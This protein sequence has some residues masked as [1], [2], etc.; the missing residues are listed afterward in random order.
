M[1]AKTFKRAVTG[2]VLGMAVG[3]LIAAL[4]GHPNIV[5]P[6]LL[7]KAGGLSEALLWQTLL[8]GVIGGVAWAGMS[9][10]ELERWPLL[11][12]CAAH[13]TLILAAFLPI[14]SFLG[15]LETP[16]EMLLMAAIM[17]VAHFIVFLIMCAVYRRQVRELNEMQKEY[18]RNQKMLGGIV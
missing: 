14:G 9:L 18:L 15:W 16:G 1:L 12:T 2:L 7:A 6:M 10:Y 5:S 4:A 13:F 17:A 11:A 3:N 8:S